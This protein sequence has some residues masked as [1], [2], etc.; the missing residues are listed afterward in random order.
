MD[1]DTSRNSSD[2][3]IGVVIILPFRQNPS[4]LFHH[5]TTN[6]EKYLIQKICLVG[7][8]GDWRPLA[9]STSTAIQP[10]SVAIAKYCIEMV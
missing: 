8:G 3:R 9:N 10:N 2:I 1:E 7:W 6:Q 5:C 4:K